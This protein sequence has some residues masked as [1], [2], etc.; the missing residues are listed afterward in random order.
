[1]VR[2]STQPLECPIR[3]N[4]RL[5][6]TLLK[7]PSVGS[8]SVRCSGDCPFFVSVRHGATGRKVTSGCAS[9][10]MAEMSKVRWIWE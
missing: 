8:F 4:T 5:L 1:M 9:L 2:S 6:M 10:V 7:M 3:V